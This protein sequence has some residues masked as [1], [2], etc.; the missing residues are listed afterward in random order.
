MPSP[1]RKPSAS[2]RPA[3]ADV[4]SRRSNSGASDDGLRPGDSAV[5]IWTLIVGI[6]ISGF[7]FWKNH[8]T[9][10]WFEEYYLLNILMLLWPPS[11]L[12]LLVLRRELSDFG[13]TI[14]DLKRG[15]IAAVIGFLLFTPVLLVVSRTP[16]AQR[17]YLGALLGNRP[18]GSGAIQGLIMTTTGYIGGTLDYG[19]LVFHEAVLGF[20]MFAWEWFFRGFLLNGLRR[21]FPLWLSIAIQA[22]LFCWLHVGKPLP[23]VCSSLAGGVVLGIVAVRFRSFLPCFL[24]HALISMGFDFA[25]LYFHFHP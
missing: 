17:Y 25:V 14:G 6:A 24:V 13:F 5:G 15:V 16:D 19:R 1:S 9:A 23:E 12:I 22:G 20:Y 8:E 11:L 7:L 2:G 21:T 4:P 10:M 3:S 18:Y